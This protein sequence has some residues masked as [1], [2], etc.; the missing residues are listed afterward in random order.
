VEKFQF[1]IAD[2]RFQ[3]EMAGGERDNAHGVVEIPW[4]MT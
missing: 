4:A 1:S 2:I 3:K